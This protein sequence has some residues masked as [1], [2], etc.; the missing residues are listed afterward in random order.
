MSHEL[1][2]LRSVFFSLFC[3]SLS[4]LL[5]LLLI[6]LCQNLIFTDNETLFEQS[7]TNVRPR[8]HARTSLC[9]CVFSVQL[10]FICHRV[11]ILRSSLSCSVQLELRKGKTRNQNNSLFVC[12]AW[13]KHT[14][15]LIHSALHSPRCHYTHTHTH[16]SV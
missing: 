12:H 16:S 9:L 5:F 7:I 1:F 3:Y 2:S 10:L 8:Q 15:A 11:L 6:P 4:F 14:H 13:H